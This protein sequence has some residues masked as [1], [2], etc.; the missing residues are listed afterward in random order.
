MRTLLTVFFILFITFCCKKKDSHY[1]IIYVNSYHKGYPPSDGVMGSMFKN[2]PA[3]T[4]HITTFYMDTKRN[5][6]S[7]M[8][9][10]VVK[11]ILQ[12]IHSLD[13]DLIVVSDDAAVKYLIAPYQHQIGVPVVY[14]GVNWSS[15]TYQLNADRIA[16]M[17]EV[18]PLHEILCYLKKQNPEFK[19]LA[20]LS[21]NSVSEIQNTLL[22]DTLYRNKGF[23]PE[24]VLVDDFEAWKKDFIALNR[25]ADVIY[26]PTNGAI[27]GWDEDEAKRWVEQHIKVPLFTCDDFM[28]P[29]A[30]VGFT[31]VAEEQGEFVA[32][33]AKQILLEK[34]SI[35]ELNEDRNKRFKSWVNHSLIEKINFVISDSLRAHSTSIQ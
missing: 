15:S 4:F 27:S 19:K 5:S 29:Y 23:T 6:D 13:P 24:Y 14:C 18:L 16:G 30:V 35:A 11:D 33:A 28:M 21:E 31:K 34:K 8:I 2:L 26:L 32:K 10:I 7:L 25:N 9:G 3:D 17:V 22:L 20:V 12:S 1:K